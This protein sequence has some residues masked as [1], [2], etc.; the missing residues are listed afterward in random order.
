M[1]F[2]SSSRMH[3]DRYNSVHLDR[4]RS[5]ELRHTIHSDIPFFGEDIGPISFKDWMWDTEKLVQPL[6]SKY[7]HID[8]L[9]HVTSRFVGR[10][11]DWWQERQYNVKKGRTSCIN[12]FYELKTCMWKHFIPPSFRITKAQQARIEDFIDIGDAFIQNIAKFS[13][14]EKDFKHNLDLLLNEQKKREKCKREQVKHQKLREFEMKREKEEFEKL[15]AQREQEEKEIKEKKKREEEQKAKEE[16]LR[17]AKEE[18]ERKELE[19]RAKIKQESNLEIQLQVVELKC[20]SKEQKDLC[21]RDLVI[22][23]SPI[24][25]MKIP[26]SKGVFPNLNSTHFSIKSFVLFSFQNFCSRFLISSSSTCFVKTHFD[27]KIIFKNHLSQSV[28]HSF[29]EVGLIPSFLIFK[30]LFSQIFHPMVFMILIPLYLMTIADLFF[31][32]VVLLFWLL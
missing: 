21:V 9:R 13:R 16:S 27:I 2:S 18:N 32:L 7:S 26:F 20:I 31:I 6:F 11:F 23:S 29:Y 10:A 25:Y 19:D 30:G 12:T 14:L 15:Y 17:K 4:H 8:I 22:N 1:S 24:P 5:H 3:I 28:K